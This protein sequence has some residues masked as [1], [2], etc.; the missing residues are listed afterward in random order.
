MRGERE[1]P[2]LC[3]AAN[4]VVR[5]A[6]SG[7]FLALCWYGLRYTHY[8]LPGGA[9]KTEVLI[10]NAGGQLLSLVFFFGLAYAL[11][12]VEK[13]AGERVRRAVS[14]TAAG[15]AALW[16]CAAGLLWI[17]SAVRV[18]EGDQAFLYGGASY[19]LEGQYFFLE[20][21]GGYMAMYPHQLALT[22]L[23]ELLFRIVGAYNYFACEII[24][25]FLAA[26]SVLMGYLVLRELTESM[27]AAVIYSLTAACCAPLI[28]YTSWVYGDIPSIFCALAAAW[29]LLRGVHSTRPGWM[30]G[31]VVMAVFAVLVR[32][33]SL[34]FLI[35]LCLVCGVYAIGKRSVRFAAAAL[36]SVLISVLAYAGV[37]RM[38]ELRSGYERWP[39]IPAVTWIDMGLHESNGCYGWYDNSAK[40][41]YYAMNYDP[42]LT[43]DAA[44][45][46]IRQHIRDFMKDPAYARLFFREK[47]LSQWN[48]PLYQSL[49]FSAKYA[50]G[51][52]PGPETFLARLT[53]EYFPLL[54]KYSGILQLLIYFG[55]LLYYMLEVRG[56]SSNLSHVLAVTVIGGF[57]FSIIW[58]A[59]ARYSFPYYVMMFPMAAA[60]YARLAELLYGCIGRIAA[61]KR[62]A[63]SVTEC[64][65]GRSGG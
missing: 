48:N 30:A 65:I 34:I 19:F 29:M 22:A 55:M 50:E 45:E 52:A 11:Y 21:P 17:Y 7:I 35:A 5:I 64:G 14:R 6:G 16:I 31:M 8:M 49:F 25:V 13:R 10:D 20:P 12:A 62:R 24:S 1:T 57:L 27:S 23:V 3:V 43:E 59:K 33:N 38:Y 40:E 41:L 18:P 37:S 54:L 9:E 51:D 26:G 58:E 32:K 42:R 4:W 56:S 46:H 47:I 15:L 44:K 39:G 2:V 36:L 60:G 28:F 63:L 61:G 53:G